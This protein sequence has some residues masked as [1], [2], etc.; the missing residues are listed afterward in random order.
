VAESSGKKGKGII[1]IVNEPEIDVKKYHDDRL[2]VYLN[3]H[4]GK[5]AFVTDLRKGG[6]PVIEISLADAYDLGGQF[7]LWEIATAIACAVMTVNSF[8]QPD[9][10]DNKT[11]T[12]S[13]ITE[14]KETG[15]LREEPPMFSFPYAD[16]YGKIDLN[17]KGS[18][19][20]HD[21]LIEYLRN[22]CKPGDYVAI[23]AYLPRSMKNTDELTRLRE[24]ILRDCMTAT[25]LGF[26][27]RFLHSTGQLHKGGPDKG[28]FVQIT[29]DVVE[30]VDIPN[31]GMT[32]GMLDKAQSLGDFE[33]LESRGRRL[34]RIHLKQ[35]DHKML[36]K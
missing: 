23:N 12:L 35:P 6:Q 3:S 32:F 1:P 21:I 31:Q 16:I 20:L 33:A 28:I 5:A 14:Y 27:P 17:G 29:A 22:V 25:T 11:R 36:L 13:K 10:Q 30:D 18:A 34:I 24:S 2:F 26:G 7:Y 19:S 15:K 4:N 9:V 8:D